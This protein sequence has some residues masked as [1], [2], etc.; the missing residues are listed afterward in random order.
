M[1]A[2]ALALT[3][4]STWSSSTSVSLASTSM[5]SSWFSVPAAVSATASGPSLVPVTVTSTVLL[6]SAPNWSVMV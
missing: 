4:L 1:P 2:G 3:R 6:D 5:V